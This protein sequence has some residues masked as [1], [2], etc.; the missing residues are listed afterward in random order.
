MRFPFFAT[1]TLLS[2]FFAMLL[3]KSFD[4]GRGWAIVLAA[5]GFLLFAVLTILAL[6]FQMREHDDT[7]AG[8][9]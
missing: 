1:T 8:D 4:Y 6:Q 7:G 3:L 9:H 2:I 5:L